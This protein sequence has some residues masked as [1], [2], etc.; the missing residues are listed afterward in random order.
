MCFRQ[1]ISDH[2][3]QSWSLQFRGEHSTEPSTSPS[4]SRGAIG[5]SPAEARGFCA[6]KCGIS[7]CPRSPRKL[8]RGRWRPTMWTVT[9]RRR[10]RRSR[11]TSKIRTQAIKNS[12][13]DVG[14]SENSSCVSGIIWYL[15]ACILSSV[16]DPKYLS[17]SPSLPPAFG[18]ALVKSQ[19]VPQLDATVGLPCA[20]CI[21]R[22]HTS[23][24]KPR[25]AC[26]RS[27]SRV[28][29]RDSPTAIQTS[30]KQINWASFIHLHLCQV[31]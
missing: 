19:D 26:C 21:H 28:A 15:L 16:F 12:Q 17:L 31:K 2:T 7:F 23:T 24:K 20:C 29:V 9:A 18:E 30:S 14:F 5:R 1:S 4:T 22:A 6:S 3:C 10:R 25:A 13:R 27:K 8:P 11:R